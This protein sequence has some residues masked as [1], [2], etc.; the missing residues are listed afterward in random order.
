[1]S[2]QG[3]SGE[4]TAVSASNARCSPDYAALAGLAY[5]E[6]KSF[7][8]PEKYKL[9]ADEER[10]LKQHRERETRRYGEIRNCAYR[11]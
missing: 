8:D 1:M 2:N 6:I 4:S 9:T 10:E 11:T 7:E 3:T 5:K